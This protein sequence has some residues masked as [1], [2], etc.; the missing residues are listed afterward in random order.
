MFVD[1][2]EVC[3]I[4]NILDKKK[5]KS[6]CIK[7]TLEYRMAKQIFFCFSSRSENDKEVTLLGDVIEKVEKYLN[8]GS[9]S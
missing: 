7:D 2:C 6:E 5:F 3:I 9:C 1:S 8:L 4:E